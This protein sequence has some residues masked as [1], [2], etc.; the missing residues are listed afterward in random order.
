M[1]NPYE[2]NI[3]QTTGFEVPNID[4]TLTDESTDSTEQQ[5]VDPVEP[6]TFQQPEQPIDIASNIGG[7]TETSQGGG[8]R[9]PD[10]S[11][12]KLRRAYY[13]SRKEVRNLPDGSPE[14]DQ[15]AMENHG[16]N[17][18]T[19]Q[20]VQEQK[21]NEKT[22]NLVFYFNFKIRNYHYSNIIFF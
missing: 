6:D 11:T 13:K 10:H 14:K 3:L 16:V 12:L 8:Y 4:I 2:E 20:S 22:Q 9:E 7:T 21:R 17:W 19:Y 15:W 18:A 5:T 1:A